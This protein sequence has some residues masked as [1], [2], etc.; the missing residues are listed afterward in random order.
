VPCDSLFL[1]PA[2][3][4]MPP[5]DQHPMP[6]QEKHLGRLPFKYMPGTLKLKL[7]LAHDFIVRECESH[8]PV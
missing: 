8:L 6:E 7:F 2:A 3:N 4:S 5:S 1:A